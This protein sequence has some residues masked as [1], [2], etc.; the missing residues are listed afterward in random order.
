MFLKLLSDVK[1]VRV[2]WCFNSL[3]CI[4]GYGIQTCGCVRWEIVV[5]IVLPSTYNCHKLNDIAFMIINDIIFMLTA[6]YFDIEVLKFANLFLVVMP[7]IKNKLQKVKK[8]YVQW[9]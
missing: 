5:S 1:Q 7:Q 9:I 8:N 3:T 4:R 2:L 6:S